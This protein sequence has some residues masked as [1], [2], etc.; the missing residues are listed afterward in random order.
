MFVDFG[1]SH[2]KDYEFKN[3]ISKNNPNYNKLSVFFYS[4]I[5]LKYLPVQ[6]PYL[7]KK[8]CC[9]FQKLIFL[10]IFF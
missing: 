10:K 5:K 8:W 1:V 3:L 6:V 7:I 2:L 4:R 9:D